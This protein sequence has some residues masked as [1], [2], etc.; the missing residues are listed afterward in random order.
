MPGRAVTVTGR[1]VAVG[2]ARL[3][4][5]RGEPPLRI[6]AWAGPWP[7]S[8]R[9]WD[10]AAARRRA[11][12]QLLTGDGRAW[13]AAVQDGRWLIEAGYWLW[14]GT[15]RRFPGA[16]CERRMAWR[17][18]G[19]ARPA[20][21]GPPQTGRGRQR[22]GGTARAAIPWAELHCHSSFSFLD[23]AATPGRARRRGRPARPGD[24]G[25]HRPRR[26]VRGPAVRAGR[27]QARATTGP[28]WARCSA[29]SSAFQGVCG[30][31]PPERGGSGGARPRRGNTVTCWSWPAT[32]KATAGCAP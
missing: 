26:D 27:G 18:E 15:T 25:H 29:P 20:R 8:E 30:A 5:G 9:W 22:P 2:R 32:P 11:R 19:A 3:A 28:A 13:L 23:G 12:F 6:T 1:C 14:A 10:P 16:S 7:L 4:G 21:R 17:S 24:A 31:V